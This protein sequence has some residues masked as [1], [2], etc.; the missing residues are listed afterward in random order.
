MPVKTIAI[1]TGG[2][3]CPGLNAVIRAVVKSAVLKYGWRV[4]GIADGFDGLIWPEKSRELRLSDVSGILP[5]GGT[6]LG[7]TNRGNPFNY[8]MEEA[9]QREERDYS[10]T[11]VRNAAEM[12]IDA[13]IVIGGDGTLKIALA[14]QAKGLNVIGVPKTIDNDLSATEVTFGFDTALHTATDAID[15]IHTTGEA[16]HRIMLVEVMGRDVGWI[17]L[18]A[19]IAGGAHVILLPEI[20]FTIQGVCNLVKRRESDGKKFTVVVVAEGIQVPSEL[21]PRFVAEKRALPRAGSVANLVGDAL[22][23]CSHRETRVT[24][25]GH[26]QRGGAPSPFDRILA[27]RFGAAAVELAARGDFGRMVCLRA[28]SVESVDLAEAVGEIK[29]VDPNGEMVRAARAIGI[30][31]GD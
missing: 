24:V 16:H 3:D 29:A 25:L 15:K 6:I 14:L 11:L 12:G 17:A 9:G 7:T 27:T 1:C 28:A 10:D 5:R 22:A 20:P 2:G 23:H 26:I 4:L 18:Q 8:R 21:Q 13:L 30:C 19:G 31:F